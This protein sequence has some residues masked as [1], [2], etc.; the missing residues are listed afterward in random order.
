MRKLTGVILVFL[1]GLWLGRLWFSMQVTKTYED[2]SFV[3][4]YRGELCND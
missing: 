3:G 4:C 2:G 1:L